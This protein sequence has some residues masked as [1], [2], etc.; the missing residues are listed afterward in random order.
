M[1][2]PATRRLCLQAAVLLMCWLAEAAPAQQAPPEDTGFPSNLTPAG[3]APH[4]V[5][6]PPADAVINIPQSVRPLPGLADD[7]PVLDSNSPEVVQ[8]E[9]ILVS[10]LPPQAKACPEAHLNYAFD[11]RFDIFAHHISR[12][13]PEAPTLYLGI[14]LFNAAA[15]P[16]KVDVLGAASYLSQPEAPFIELNPLADNQAGNVYAGP[17]D[18]VA[19]AVLRGLRQSGWPASVVVP[20]S[21]S[22]V[23]ACL[24]IPVKGLEPPLNGRTV[25]AR[26]KAHGKIYAAT[27]TLFASLNAD[28]SERFPGPARWQALL[29]SGGLAGPREKPASTP[30]AAGAIFYGRVAGV[31]AGSLWRAPLTNPEK[32]GSGT[33]ALP[34]ADLTVSYPVSSAAGATLGTDQVQ[35]APLLVREPGT[36]FASHGN[37]GLTYRLAASFVNTCSDSRCVRVNLQTPLKTIRQPGGL[38]FFASQ[39]AK[40][41]FRGTVKLEYNDDEGTPTRRFLHLVE[42]EGQPGPPLV[43]LRLRPRERRRFVM[44][45]IYPADSTPPQVVT[46]SSAPC[47]LQP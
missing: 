8:A 28:G 24:P 9:G 22:A 32:S 1:I 14:L 23:L 40:V 3:G 39:S 16:V 30:G 4:T 34:C 2:R 7:V 19:D 18:R 38:S 35:S 42:H 44:S 13:N 47:S 36:A 5:P 12:Q 45:F 26:L 11:G 33:F 25:L 41:F 6:V 21:G 46:I 17:G 15:H 10:T 31:S 29:Q 20:A 37:Y 27:A 43:T